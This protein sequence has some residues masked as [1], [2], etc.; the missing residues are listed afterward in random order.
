LLLAVLAVEG[1]LRGSPVARA[2]G[3]Q[4][5]TDRFG[6][7]LPAG[8]VARLGTLRLRPGTFLN[9]VAFAPDG[10]ALV[11]SNWGFGVHLWDVASG[12]QLRYFAGKY[13]IRALTLSSDGNWLAAVA[14]NDPVIRLWEVATGKELRRFVGHTKGRLKVAFSPRGQVLASGCMDATVRLWDAATGKELCRLTGHK[15][16]VWSLGWS[17]DGKLLASGDDDGAIRLWQADT[18]RFLRELTGHKDLVAHLAWSPDGK[19][20]ASGGS[21]GTVRLWDVDTGTARH[22]LGTGEDI[23][24]RPLPKEEPA[25]PGGNQNPVGELGCNHGLAFSPDGTTLFSASQ[26]YRTILIWNVA[27]GQERRRL[28]GKQRVF[29]LAL[30]ADG[31]TLA[32]GGAD[33]QIDLWDVAAGKPLHTF[34]GPRG[35]IFS[36]PFSPDGKV[37]AT[38]GDDP[39]IRLWRTDTW[40]EIRQLTGHR[41]YVRSLVFSPDGKYV[42]GVGP[43][44]AVWV[45]DLGTGKQVHAFVD[46]QR[47]DIDAVTFSPDGKMLAANW[48]G[49]TVW[50]V[51]SG[52]ELHSFDQREDELRMT[53]A[54]AF[55]PDSRGLALGGHGTIHLCDPRTGAVLRLF[56]PHK[57]RVNTLAFSADGKTL[58][59]GG[60]D[61]RLHLWEVAT[62]TERRA[63]AGHQMSIHSAAWS[64]DGKLVASASGSFRNHEDNSVRVWDAA[65]GEELRRFTAHPTGV[66]SV[67]FSPDGKTLASASEDTTVLVWD[68][69]G[70]APAARPA[71]GAL[72]AADQ[73]ALWTAL[74]D[75]HASKADAAMQRLLSRPGQTTSFLGGRLRPAGAE[76]RQIGQWVADLDS[77][78]FA[79]RSKA[80]QALEQV[81]E[82]AEPALRKA[83]EGQP[84]LDL[85]RQIERLL[86]KARGIPSGE[87]LR[88]LRAVE[89]LEHLGTPEA[90]QV[91]ET[92]SRG[93]AEARLT[94]EAR[95]SLARLAR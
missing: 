51:A 35:R 46:T 18:G 36:A 20:L 27:T 19:T 4:P 43:R 32:V 23:R 77:P 48:H 30:S 28:P 58:L 89:V 14:V 21:D 94:Q 8:A 82:A 45:W 83:L 56:E 80:A 68:V 64:P 37:L 9:T 54:V 40:Q 84:S 52:K 34:D 86:Q 93:A 12:K 15:G 67:V 91:L 17:A 55:S 53:S 6:D 72:P 31:K 70:L 16:E 79:V 71:L 44:H 47:G 33:A 88:E 95:A 41:G 76:A 73:E 66:C 7:P 26:E 85:R 2:D 24:K 62:G 22:T 61:K 42:A 75:G 25:I 87:R 57:G 29:S 38:G 74:A 5:A 69:S 60:A 90:R 1:S 65:T 92:L 81:G 49:A 3:P 11:S 10:K 39:A 13:A 78:R 50:N 63:F 59:S